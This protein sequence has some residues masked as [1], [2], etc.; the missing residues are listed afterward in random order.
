MR[1]WQASRWKCPAN[2]WAC[3]PGAEEKRGD[4]GS[5]CWTHPQNADSEPRGWMRPLGTPILKVVDPEPAMHR[6]WVTEGMV[7]PS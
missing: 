5:R 1:T 2:P 7:E 3:E 4:C 6:E